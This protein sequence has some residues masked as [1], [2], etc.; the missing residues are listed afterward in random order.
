MNE[1]ELQM[2]LDYATGFLGYGDLDAPYWFVG[3][4]EGGVNEAAQALDRARVWHGW[5]PPCP[6]VLDL[7][8]YVHQLGIVNPLG[9]GQ[10][11]WRPLI[12][13]LL[14]YA[15]EERANGANQ[16]VTNAEILEFQK[17]RWGRGG[18]KKL[19][20]L[21][22]LFG[23][24]T[25]SSR[26]WAYANCGQEQVNTRETGT[27]TTFHRRREN[28]SV[29]LDQRLEAGGLKL[30]LFYARADHRTTLW[31]EV[32]KIQNWHICPNLNGDFLWQKRGKTL[33]LCIGHP[34]WGQIGGDQEA[35]FMPNLALQAQ[36]L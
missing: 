33:F 36:K 26:I 13:F 32:C 35:A 15:P 6:Q 21:L 16:D 17:T 23:L 14:Y 20:C 31:S 3:A 28:F 1:H 4:E 9:H 19:T 34:G 18:D 25:R 8:E 29:A 22:E 27:A 5:N 7:D 10:N 2:L 30:V 24:P 12:R 11:T